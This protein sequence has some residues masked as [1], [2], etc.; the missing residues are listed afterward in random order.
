MMMAFCVT[1]CMNGANQAA[2]CDG[3]ARLRTDHAAALAEDAGPK[4][5]RTGAALI[6]TLDAGCG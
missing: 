6:K 1:G 2:V 5:L 4:S 3:S